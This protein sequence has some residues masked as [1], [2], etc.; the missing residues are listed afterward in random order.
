MLAEVAVRIEPVSA[1]KFPANRQI[2]R[3]FYRLRPSTAIFGAQTAREF[4]GLQ[5]NSLR[6][7]TANFFGAS[8]EFLAKNREFSHP[9]RVSTFLLLCKPRYPRSRA[10]TIAL[11]KHINRGSIDVLL[12]EKRELGLCKRAV[13]LSALDTHRVA[14]SLGSP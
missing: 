4:N 3:E 5:P 11:V 12:T 9:K 13:L 2:N 10:V 14:T 8:R 7:G 1:V 6:N